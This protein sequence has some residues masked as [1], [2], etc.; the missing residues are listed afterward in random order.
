MA[1]DLLGNY[2]ARW[3]DGT[4]PPASHRARCMHGPDPPRRIPESGPRSP[5]RG[6]AGLAA[7]DEQGLGRATDG[8]LLVV[9]GGVGEADAVGGGGGR[10]QGDPLAGGMPQEVY[11]QVGV[12]EPPGMEVESGADAVAGVG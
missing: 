9:E 8:A 12:D 2:R 4:R 3:V 11:R 7:I 6:L 1:P 5:P 10:L